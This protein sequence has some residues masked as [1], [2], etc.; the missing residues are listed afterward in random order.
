M[1]TILNLI[2][3]HL[4][5]ALTLTYISGIICSAH[6]HLPITH[7][8]VIIFAISCAIFQI[9]SR[10]QKTSTSTFILSFFLF[11]LAGIIHGNIS[12]R[13]P[14]SPNHIFNLIDKPTDAVIV[15]HLAKMPAFDSFSSQALIETQSIT[16]APSK[17][18][19]PAHGRILLK[20]STPW[21]DNYPPGT[22]LAIR[23]TLQRPTRF[24][25]PGTFDYPAYLARKDI[26]ITGFSRSPAQL[27]SVSTSSNTGQFVV[28]Q[29]RNTIG[30]FIDQHTSSSQIAAIYRAILLGDRSRIPGETLDKF[31][32]SGTMHILAISG[33]HM[34]LIGSLLFC[35]TYWFLRRSSWLMLNCNAKKLSGA[36][37]LPLIAGYTLL[38]G[39][40]APVLRAG[41]MSSILILAFCID[42]PKTVSSLIALGAIVILTLSPQ[43]LYTVSFQLSFAA[44]CSIMLVI[45]L[46]RQLL[47]DTS[48]AHTVKREKLAMR[49]IKWITASL[50]VSVVASLGTA[51]LTLFFSTGF[52]LQVQ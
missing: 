25:V 38:A 21:P 45:P 28:E 46:L 12:S 32:A 8:G 5:A 51:P 34:T 41:I 1:K 6:Y 3:A 40:N 13:T 50:V 47:T 44:F 18:F 15:G 14:Q 2:D 49:A 36:I 23:A 20:L 11:F 7:T 33:L 19:T 10:L 16:I 17:S 52:P 35:C 24:L 42:R 22:L 39:G 29:L 43:S 30:N 48:L 27:H 26:W 37:C 4:F 31:K 9:S